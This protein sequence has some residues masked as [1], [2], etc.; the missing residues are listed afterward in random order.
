MLCFC[1]VLPPENWSDRLPNKGNSLL[2][3]KKSKLPSLGS[4]DL[5]SEG[6]LDFNILKIKL[7]RAHLISSLTH[8]N[9]G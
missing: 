1:S 4:I 6:N 9:L 3:F 2:Y 7:T 5:Q 8:P